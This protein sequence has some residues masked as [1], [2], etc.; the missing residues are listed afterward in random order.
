M[1]DNGK[2][3]T[4]DESAFG[5]VVTL[6]AEAT[7][8]TAAPLA[9]ACRDAIAAASDGP[10]LIDLRATTMLDSTGLTVI[11]ACLRDAEQR[12]WQSTIAY[13]D[14]RIGQILTV[15]RMERLAGTKL[16]AV[17]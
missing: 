10:L 2:P 1:S 4:L 7:T 13:R 17:S 3:V 11:V 12:G 14:Q 8:A 15:V 16:L 5:C 9:R 6:P